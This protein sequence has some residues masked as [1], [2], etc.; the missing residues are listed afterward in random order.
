MLQPVSQSESPARSGRHHAAPT[1]AQSSLDARFN[2][3]LYMDPPIMPVSNQLHSEAHCTF[4][5]NSDQVRSRPSILPV[6]S[7]KCSMC[8]PM[9]SIMVRKRLHIGVSLR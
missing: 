7:P 5:R 3:S 1:A 4:W 8:T 6:E 2:G 9:R